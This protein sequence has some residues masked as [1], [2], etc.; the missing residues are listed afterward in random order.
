[1][2]RNLQKWSTERP[3]SLRAALQKVRKLDGNLPRNRQKQCLSSSPSSE[4]GDLPL[5]N[6]LA[7][8]VHPGARPYNSFWRWV[9]SWEGLIACGCVL[10][11]WW[12]HMGRWWDTSPISWAALLPEPPGFKCFHPILMEVAL[13]CRIQESEGDQAIVWSLRWVLEQGDLCSSLLHGYV[14]W[15]AEIGFPAERFLI[16]RSCSNVVQKEFAPSQGNMLNE[17]QMQAF[18]RAQGIR[19][20]I[21]IS[22][23]WIRRD[24]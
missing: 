2:V 6:M 5:S 1:M 21:I 11:S 22:M 10:S 12:G 14:L 13:E 9:S 23:V 8:S 16:T 24:L 18:E 7:A 17:R 3:G 4:L 15:L 20:N 19:K